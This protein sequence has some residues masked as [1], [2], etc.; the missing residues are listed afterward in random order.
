MKAPKKRNP[1][2]AT[3]RNIRALKTRVATLERQMKRVLKVVFPDGGVWLP[4]WSAR[5]VHVIKRK[6]KR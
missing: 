3:L 4:V 2:D 6:V 1:Q 5:G